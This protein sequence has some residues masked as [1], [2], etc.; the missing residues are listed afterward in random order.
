[1]ILSYPVICSMRIAGLLMLQHSREVAVKSEILLNSKNRMLDTL[2]RLPAHEHY[3][4]RLSHSATQQ[5]MACQMMDLLADLLL[6]HLLPEKSHDYLHR[7][8]TK[9]PYDHRLQHTLMS[10]SEV[11]K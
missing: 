8:L 2:L 7:T 6:A 5:D 1:M 11:S 3:H 9:I 4:R 10:V